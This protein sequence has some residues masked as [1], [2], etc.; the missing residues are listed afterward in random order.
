MIE[1]IAV[2]SA[3]NGRR[4]ELVLRAEDEAAVDFG[5]VRERLSLMLNRDADRA[6]TILFVADQDQEEARR[7]RENPPKRKGNAGPNQIAFA[8]SDEAVELDKD[9]TELRRMKAGKPAS[10]TD[11]SR[12]RAR[13]G[14]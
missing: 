4:V 6:A 7:L 12:A 8:G 2:A 1:L 9:G 13:K 11:K 10:Q 14:R 5:D 3:P